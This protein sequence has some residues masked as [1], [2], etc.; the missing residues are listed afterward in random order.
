MAIA[1]ETIFPGGTQEMYENVAG[2]V[3]P[4]QQLPEGCRLHVAGPVDEGW[5][6]FTVWES[7][8]H[9]ER[10]REEK[11]LPALQETGFEGDAAAQ[12]NPAYRVIIA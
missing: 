5:R 10:F 11:L 2:R 4:N 8:E 7:R 1:V 3:V 12:V 9:L 6:V